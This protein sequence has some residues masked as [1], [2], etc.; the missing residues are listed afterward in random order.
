MH[1]TDK[2]DKNREEL[3]KLLEIHSQ[4]IGLDPQKV[5][6]QLE[7]GIFENDLKSLDGMNLNNNSIET[8]L[9]SQKA[10]EEI[11]RMMNSTKE[12]E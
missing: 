5:K 10:Q 3:E 1:F 8:F 7:K 12:G 2:N 11:L 4:K 9:N 6:N